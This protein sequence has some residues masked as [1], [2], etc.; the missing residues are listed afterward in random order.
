METAAANRRGDGIADVPLAARI[1]LAADLV[2]EADITVSPV[3]AGTQTS[4]PT[5]SLPQVTRFRLAH[6]L[7]GDDTLMLRYLAAGR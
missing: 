7:H 6:V 3:F 2:D 4:P 5:P 1:V